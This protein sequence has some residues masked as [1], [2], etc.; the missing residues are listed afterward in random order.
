DTLVAGAFLVAATLLSLGHLS[1]QRHSCRWGISRG[2]DTLVA[3][4]SLVA[5]TLLS[6]AIK[7]QRQECRC[8][9]WRHSL[10]ATGVSLPSN[11]RVNGIFM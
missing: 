11:Q 5:A 8:Y 2:S 7:I 3:G 10:S 4:A 9:D 6:L 1:W